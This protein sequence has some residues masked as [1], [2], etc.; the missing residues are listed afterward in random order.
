MKKYL[1][2][3]LLLYLSL[4]SNYFI[5]SQT[6]STHAIHLGGDFVLAPNVQFMDDQENEHNYIAGVL[7]YVNFDN[8]VELK[9]GG[10]YHIK[11]Y[12]SY[13]YYSNG[14]TKAITE[15]HYLNIP[16]TLNLYLIRQKKQWCYLLGGIAFGLPIVKDKGLQL[17]TVD[18]MYISNQYIDNTNYSYIVGM[19]YK[20]TLNKKKTLFFKMEPTIMF[21]INP[22]QYGEYYSSNIFNHVQSE[23]MIT[24]NHSKASLLL[25]FT[26]SYDFYKIKSKK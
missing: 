13:D 5:F 4:S 9:F 21:F 11:K 12:I 15:F 6:D 17:H 16:V 1:F 22:V 20:T 23:G 14:T 18:Y 25:S 3:F 26:L 2:A 8:V 10:L 19:G 24:G 7:F